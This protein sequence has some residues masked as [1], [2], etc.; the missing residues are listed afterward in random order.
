M[1]LRL[2]AGAG[3]TGSATAQILADAGDRVRLVSRRG[4][5]PDHPLIERVRA[6]ASDPGQL[7]EV[8]EGAATIFNCVMPPYDQWADLWPPLATSLL[9]TA[10]R[11]RADY[12]MLGNA[13][14]Y[15]DVPV[16]TEITP[17][18]PS[19][20]KGRVKAKMWTDAL[21][22]QEAGRVRVTEVRAS[23]YL[24]AAAGSV[25]N[26]TVTQQVLRGQP[27]LYPAP[28]DVPHAWTAVGDVGRALATIG[29]DDR[30]FG[31]AW[32]VPSVAVWSV[33]D[34]TE[35]LA[36]L[37]GSPVPD[38]RGMSYEDL[39]EAG[40]NDAILQEL[41]EIFYLDAKPIVFD[42]TL[43]EETFALT[44]SSLD[45]VLLDTAAVPPPT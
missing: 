38:V 40:A 33:R 15:G 8:A 2:I 18:E 17:I 5:G 4:A 16:M 30:A 44:T 9:Q 31:R 24:G 12:V 23:D 19:S 34:L 3:P 32:H 29:L 25:F 35:R 10:E 14:A 1:T 22:A 27:V 11:V 41:V 42:T 28:V 37:T 26:F 21:A 13:Y 6:D 36:K 20:V 39:V 7:T 45:D 43:T